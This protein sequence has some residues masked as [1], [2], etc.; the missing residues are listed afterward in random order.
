[1]FIWRHLLH[2]LSSS[3][4]DFTSECDNTHGDFLPASMT[5]LDIAHPQVPALVGVTIDIS[6]LSS[7]GYTAIRDSNNWRQ[8]T[9]LQAVMLERHLT[10]LKNLASSLCCITDRSWIRLLM[11]RTSCFFNQ[12]SSGRY[13]INFFSVCCGAQCFAKENQQL[14]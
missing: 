11:F 10:L 5:T 3:N 13:V 4:T 2:L 6:G 9:Y 7:S 8:S 1:M 14:N 12:M